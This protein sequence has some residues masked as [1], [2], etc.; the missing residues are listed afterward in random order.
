MTRFKS[1]LF[2]IV[3]LFTLY[4]FGADNSYIPSNSDRIIFIG[5]SIT[6]QGQLHSGGWGK[7]V[8]EALESVGDAKSNA[9]L[10]GGSGHTIGSWTNVEKNS[11]TKDIYLDSK[12]LN[13]GKEIDKG[14]KVLV[15]MLGMNDVLGPYLDGSQKSV[16]NWGERYVALVNLFQSR[17]KAEQVC[18][19]TVTLCTE[20]FSSYK[21][22]LVDML[23]AKIKQIA[24]EN[25]YSVAT[26]SDRYKE[27]LTNGRKYLSNFHITGDYV[28]PNNDGHV[29]IALGMLEGL[30][31]TKEAEYLRQK[32]YQNIGK[33]NVNGKSGIS[34][35]VVSSEPIANSEEQKYKIRYN[36]YN[37]SKKLS[38][39]VKLPEGWKT[40]QP[41]LKTNE[42]VFEVRGTP[43][44][45]LNKVTLTAKDGSNVYEKSIDIPAP[46]LIQWG[47]KQPNWNREK[48][49]VNGEVYNTEIDKALIAGS[50]LPKG[51]WSIYNPSYNYTGRENPGSIDFAAKTVCKPFDGGYGA[52]WIYSAKDRKAKLKLSSQ[53]FAGNIF[54]TVW[55]DKNKVYQDEITAKQRKTDQLEVSLK[56]GWNRL[57]FKSNR[58][59]WQWQQSVE[60]LALD[61]DSLEDLRFSILE[62]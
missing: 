6:A 37:I 12:K 59:S 11:R 34:C 17:V 57:V 35:E 21:N 38:V 14:A 20:D 26:T 7:Y 4:S 24:S 3:C 23:N 47:V 56:K 5:D 30:K 33:R 53:I 29:S 31:K 62:K 2:S 45:L 48:P 51:N 13:I 40:S 44:Q 41:T 32:Y 25:G 61:G 36:L 19:A 54:L 39:E 22:T 50:H 8:R 15:I 46:W 10:L 18:L 1:F 49:P 52:R 16:D 9:V 58:I 27:A 42:G 43:D 28:H 60:L 55:I